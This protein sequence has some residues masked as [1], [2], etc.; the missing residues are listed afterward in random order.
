MTAKIPG[1]PNLTTARLRLRPLTLDDAAPM[2]ALANDIDIARMTTSIPHPFLAEHA[3]GFI[4]RMAARDLAREAVF[5][6]ELPSQ[7]LVGVLGLHPNDRGAPELGYWLGQAHWGRGYMT[8]AVAAVLIWAR[9]EWNRGYLV[10]GHFEDN[11]A[12]GAVLCKA[13]FLYTGE[14]G[15]RFSVARGEIALTR[16]MVWLA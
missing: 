13:G 5:A 7:G 1:A 9:E 12:S 15:E 16:M 4:K 10:S 14:R 11:P 8:E 6:L 2:T 3:E